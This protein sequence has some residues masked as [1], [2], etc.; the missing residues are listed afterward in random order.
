MFRLGRL[1]SGFWLNQRSGGCARLY[2][3]FCIRR[4]WGGCNK[5]GSALVL[6]WNFARRRPAFRLV[7]LRDCIGI[8]PC[9]TGDFPA[10]NFQQTRPNGFLVNGFRLPG[11]GR[12]GC[13]RSCTVAAFQIL[14]NPGQVSREVLLQFGR[15]E[16]V[17]PLV[18]AFRGCWN[19]VP[20]RIRG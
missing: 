17:F 19:A 18:C 4:G 14:A 6:R 12:Y 9:A 8:A 16:W 10:V 11:R 20:V 7:W 1:F 15:A 13:L 2:A 5:P 3:V